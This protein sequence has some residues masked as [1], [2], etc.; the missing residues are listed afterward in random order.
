MKTSY[1]EVTVNLEDIIVT[2][3]NP[4]SI[5]TNILSVIGGDAIKLQLV[6]YNL[7]ETVDY[8]SDHMKIDMKMGCAKIIFMNWFI[9]SVLN[10]L[11]HFQTAQD[12]IKE[13]SKAAA[14]AAK[15]SAVQAYEQATRIKMNIRIKAP[16]IIIPVDSKSQNGIMIDLG[17]LKITNAIN[18]LHVESDYGPAVIDEMKIDLTDVKLSKVALST[19]DENESGQRN[20]SFFSGEKF[21]NFFLEC[22][23]YLEIPIQIVALLPASTILFSAL[24]ALL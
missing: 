1:T 2:D 3:M 13:A 10:F 21:Y 15:Q 8:N 20:V 24:R 22:L 17:K 12:R 16:I 7:E 5:H 4:K 18:N 9:T 11:D 23:S 19:M 6:L 14:V